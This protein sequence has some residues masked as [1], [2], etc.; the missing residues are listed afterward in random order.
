MKK[1]INII[2]NQLLAIR[3]GIL[4][5]TEII[6]EIMKIDTLGI[7]IG[8]IQRIILKKIKD[9]KKTKLD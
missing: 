6:Q 7:I 4:T 2:I 9:I 3:I 1:M 8:T 5:K